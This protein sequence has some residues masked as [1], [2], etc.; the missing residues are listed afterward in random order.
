MGKSKCCGAEL[1]VMV[2]YYVCDKCYRCTLP[3]VFHVPEK[4]YNAEAEAQIE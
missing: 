4:R 1:L 2:D 3:T